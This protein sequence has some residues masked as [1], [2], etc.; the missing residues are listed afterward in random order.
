MPPKLP[1]SMPWQ[2]YQAYLGGPSA[3]LRLFED[4]FGRHALHGPP[5]AD[6]QQQQIDDLS[7]HIGQ[8]K[9]QI[10][11]LQAEI[12]ELRG[13]NFQLGRR[14]AELEALITKDSHNSSRPPSTDPP[15]AK[16]TKSLRRPS[17]KRPGGQAGHRGATLRLS[18]R[19][20]RIVEH[21]PQKC[22][23]CHAPFTTAQAVRHLRQQVVEVVPARLRVTE[24]RLAVLRCQACGQTTQGEFAGR[25]RSGV[26]YR[27]GVRARVLYLQQYQLLPY[28]RT[29][30]AMRDLF[31]CP[32]SAGTVAN[33]VRECADELVETEL[34]IKRGLRHAPVIH[35][36][37]TGLHING[38]LGYV[39]VAS[40]PRLTHYAAAHRGQTA[41]SEI[42]VLPRYRGTCVQ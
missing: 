17:G 24:H 11:R 20:D 28:Q 41:I 31:A 34:K 3:L 32:L 5:D 42:N 15:W 38:R 21:R 18:A 7:A 2:I 1:D 12:S 37:E 40:T 36:D 39:H 27:P 25:V 22:R 8:L 16:R 35:A 30:E 14:N 19:P 9:S 13:R 6:Q 29:S 10:K 4:A 26:Q 33:I 23:G